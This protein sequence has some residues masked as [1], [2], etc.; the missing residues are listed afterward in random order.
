[1]TAQHTRQT[2]ETM[3]LTESLAAGVVAIDEIKAERDRL[4]ALVGELTAALK[5]IQADLEKMAA[6]NAIASAAL[7]KAKGP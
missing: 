1:M 3:T 7:A 2:G 5:K 6:N 4:R